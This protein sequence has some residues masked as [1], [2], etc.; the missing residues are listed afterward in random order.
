MKK[1][2]FISF[3]FLLTF[4]FTVE[5]FLNV[6]KAEEKSS[7]DYG[8]LKQ[9]GVLD[10]SVSEE[11]WN[12]FLGES[13]VAEQEVSNEATTIES[14]AAFHLKAGDVLIS[15]ATSSRGLTG[16]AAI[17]ISSSKILHIHSAGHNPAVHNLSWFKKRYSGKGHW[18]KIYRS[19][20]SKAGAKAAAWAKKNYV[21]KKYK[22]GI[23]TKLSSKNPT[24]CS[25]IIY[26]AY[27]YGASKKS[28][29]D[30]GS[31]IIAPYALP[32]I[33][34]KAYKLRNVKTY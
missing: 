7:E 10:N 25:K 22:Y 11:Q 30:P 17:A 14:R 1:I 27:K 26:Q 9:E 18:L 13:E 2:L 20:N 34:S 31:H 12:Q 23:N 24:Y 4:A 16:H 6:T 3:A 29:Y 28:I 15:N 8:E 32:N 33:S 21:G 5:S 19:K